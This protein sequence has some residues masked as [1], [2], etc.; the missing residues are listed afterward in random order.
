MGHP[1]TPLFVKTHDFT[2][3]LFQHTGRFPKHLRY[4]YTNRLES[5]ALGFEE[6]LLMANAARGQARSRWLER[7]DGRLVCLRALLRY[8]CGA[9]TQSP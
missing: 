7:A 4:T 2:L 3:W 6:A 1:D 8:R 5:L 9:G